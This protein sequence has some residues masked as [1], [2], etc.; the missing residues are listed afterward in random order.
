MKWLES[1]L[2]KVAS[3]FH[4]PAVEEAFNTV[5][6]IIP[7]AEPIVADI[8]ALTPNKTVQ[9]IQTAYDKYAV[10][11]SGVVESDPNAVGNALLNLATT[12]VNKNLKSPAAQNLVN[13]A[14]Q[15]AVTAAKAGSTPAPAPTPAPS[16]APAA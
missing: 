4:K 12:V 5:A 8:A 2:G 1:F 16:A 3:W 6:K 11:F 13:T 9:E 14:V 7:E 10:P 15:L